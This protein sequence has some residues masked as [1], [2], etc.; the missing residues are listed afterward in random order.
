MENNIDACGIVTATKVTSLFGLQAHSAELVWTSTAETTNG[1]W[2]QH[3]VCQR[4][5]FLV[6][7]ISTTTGKE[8]WN[9]ALGQYS[10]LDFNDLFFQEEQQRRPN[11]DRK[12]PYPCWTVTMCPTCRTYSLMNWVRCSRLSFKIEYCGSDNC[13]PLS[14]PSMGLDMVIG[15]H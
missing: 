10:A 9:V 7:H 2:Q 15:S 12:K 8:L 3:V 6:K 11:Q 14:P 13:I 4:E 5:D 1:L